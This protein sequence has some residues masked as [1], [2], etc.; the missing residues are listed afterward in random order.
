M[1]CVVEI[2][3]YFAFFISIVLFAKYGV[4]YAILI[5]AVSL[6][7]DK[8]LFSSVFVDCFRLFFTGI[9][10]YYVI[11]Q[12]KEKSIYFLFLFLNFY[13]FLGNFKIFLFTPGLLF[14]F[15]ALSI[16]KSEKKKVL[17]FF[18]NLTYSMYLL[19]IPIMLIIILIFYNLNLPDTVFLNNY[20]FIF[21]ISIILTVSFISFKFFE[22]PVNKL[23]RKKFLSN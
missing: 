22:K 17:D 15:I 12:L 20:F 7:T 13:F 9:I 1:E 8:F 3:I 2:L 18:G 4:K 16:F 10:V 6:L 23:F 19:H 14:L 11:I 21:Y 5:Y